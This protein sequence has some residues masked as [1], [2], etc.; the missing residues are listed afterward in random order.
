[1]RVGLVLT[2]NQSVEK[3]ARDRHIC[4]WIEAGNL[5]EKA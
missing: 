4:K 2:G 5:E 3:Y 1:M